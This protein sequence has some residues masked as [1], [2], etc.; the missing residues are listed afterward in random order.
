LTDQGELSSQPGLEVVNDRPA[1]DLAHRAALVGAAATD[2]LLDGIEPRDALE[3]FAGDRRRTGR[4]ELVEAAAN[5]GPAEGELDVTTL[6]EDPIA[7]VAVNLENALE[8]GEMANRPLGLAVGRIEVDDARWIGAAAPRP[9]IAR[10][11]P[12]LAEFGAPSA[13]IEHRS[14]GLIGKQFGRSL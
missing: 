5:M 7:A 6:G 12:Q 11:G 2:F 9:I 13:G 4:G 14:R 8:A 3:R 1:P 10:I